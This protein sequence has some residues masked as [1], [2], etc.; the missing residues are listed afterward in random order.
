M[1]INFFGWGGE[2]GNSVLEHTSIKIYI[3][4]SRF[5]IFTFRPQTTKKKKNY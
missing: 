2:H 3:P 5:L 1:K 4:K